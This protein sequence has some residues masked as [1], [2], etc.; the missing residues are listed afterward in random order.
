MPEIDREALSEWYKTIGRRGGSASSELSQVAQILAD[1][2]Y[3]RLAG[4]VREIVR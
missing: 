4:R 1:Q 2:V 3:R